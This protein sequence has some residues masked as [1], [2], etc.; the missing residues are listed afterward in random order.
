[1]KTLIDW[2]NG[3][4]EPRRARTAKE[5]GCEALDWSPDELRNYLLIAVV[6]MV[7]VNFI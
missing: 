5:E 4:P 1:M 2:M 3:T 6:I 7:L